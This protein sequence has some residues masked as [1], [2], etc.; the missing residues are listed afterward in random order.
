M[1]LLGIKQ[2]L[3]SMSYTSETLKK[4]EYYEIIFLIDR[5]E[6]LKI[7]GM[8]EFLQKGDFT[9]LRKN[10]GKEILE[11]DTGIIYK[12]IA[13]LAKTKHIDISYMGRIVRA[14]PKQYQC[15]CSR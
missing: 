1:D 7:K 3:N 11:T 12:S 6:E 15:I 4:L 10:R 9:P 13:D 14:N 2:L 8:K 5:A